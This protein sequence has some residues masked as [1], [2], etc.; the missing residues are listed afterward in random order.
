GSEA[1][2]AGVR[3]TRW[4]PFDADRPIATRIDMVAGWLTEPAT[5]RPRFATLY[6]EHPDSSAHA[7]GPRSAQ[8][9]ATM[10]EIDAA[11]GT[12]LARLEAAGVRDTTDLVIVSDHGMAEVPE[13]Q[14]V[15]TEDMADPE[16]ATL[17]MPGQV[18]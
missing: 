8:L 11:V 7:H 13:D 9:R 12:L 10:R 2:V 1:P 6:F 18:I 3:P 15:A 4:H 14:V 17:V 5:T 16:I